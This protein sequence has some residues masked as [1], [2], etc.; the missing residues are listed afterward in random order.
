MTSND[1]FSVI[2]PNFAPMK[3]I[4]LLFAIASFWVSSCT[5]AQTVGV[6]EFEKGLTAQVQLLDVRTPG[7]YQD[8]HL[9]NARLMDVTDDSFETE[10]QSLDKK[11]PV[12]VYCKSGKRSHT[13]YNMLKEKGFE[14]VVELKGG[15]TAWQSAGKEIVAD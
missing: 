1:H 15:I 2:V 9:R 6:K 7:E 14:N 8:G 3:N 12:Y 11:K 13:A 5:N 10:I 4:I